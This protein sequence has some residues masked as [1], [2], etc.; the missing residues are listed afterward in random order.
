MHF[1]KVVIFE[2][3]GANPLVDRVVRENPN[4]RMTIVAVPAAEAI[5]EIAAELV[6]TGVTLI[7]L[8]GGISPAWRTA[9]T[10]ATKGDA[11]VSSIMFGIDS[12]PAAARYNAAFERGDATSQA[13]ILLEPGE[14]RSREPFV[15]VPNTLPTTMI[16]VADEGEAVTTAAK[17]ADQ[18]VQLIELYGGFSTRGI[19][20]ILDAVAS[21][22]AVG[23]GSFA[24]DGFDPLVD[25]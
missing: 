6:T 7:E 22:S 17:L 9:V 18:G 13:F 19:G 15:M 1:D 3:P 5:A 11:L 10:D 20:H 21:R 8:C 12:L 25:A 4:G 23:A 14:H 16:P 2:A 24:L